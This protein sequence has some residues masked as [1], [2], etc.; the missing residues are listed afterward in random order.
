MAHPPQ[1]V[2]LLYLLIV[3]YLG[4]VAQVCH[5]PPVPLKNTNYFFF[6]VAQVAHLAQVA[7]MAQVCHVTDFGGALKLNCRG[8]AFLNTR[9]VN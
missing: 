1:Y 6:L 9:V 7:Q 3:N 8:L 4:L 2:M 5:V